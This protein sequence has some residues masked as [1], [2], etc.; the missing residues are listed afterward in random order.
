MCLLFVVIP[1]MGIV[2]RLRAGR[3]AVWISVQVKEFPFLQD[4]QTDPGAHSASCATST[5]I[6]CRALDTY[7]YLVQRL[8]I[9]GTIP[10]FSLYIFME[11]SGTVL[12]FWTFW[13]LNCVCHSGMWFNCQRVEKIFG[14]GPT[15][16]VRIE[17]VSRCIRRI[18]KPRLRGGFA[19]II[20]SLDLGRFV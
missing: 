17:C 20:L 3:S 5:G 16:L 4:I 19:V 10:L 9:S 6:L 12:L 18:V 11:C 7:I 13:C 14:R 1:T 8:R 2:T 15:E